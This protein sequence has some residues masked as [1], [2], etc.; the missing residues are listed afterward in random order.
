MNSESTRVDALGERHERIRADIDRISGRTGIHSNFIRR[1]MA[2]WCEEREVEWVRH[3]R[4]HL[5]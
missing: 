5:D 2:E 1:S 4:K 3:L